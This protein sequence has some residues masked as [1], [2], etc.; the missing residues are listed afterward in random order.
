MKAF[1]LLVA[2]IAAQSFAYNTVYNKVEFGKHTVV[3][4]QTKELQN[5]A[6]VSLVVDMK[7]RSGNEPMVQVERTMKKS[8]EHKQTL[9]LFSGYDMAA[10]LY[11]RT[12]EVQVKRDPSQACFVTL[13]ASTGS[14]N[15]MSAA[16]VTITPS[17]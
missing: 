8:C 1:G 7:S 4:T 6:V 9:L 14:Q 3:N 11:K 5:E 15:Q 16:R 10:K 17:K 2:L 12:Y 13:Y